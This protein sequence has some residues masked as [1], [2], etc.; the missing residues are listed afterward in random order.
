MNSARENILRVLRDR[1]D[2]VDPSQPAASPATDV[3]RD[4]LIQMFRSRAADE[5]ATSAVVERQADVAAEIGRY[6]AEQGLASAVHVLGEARE[7]AL[8]WAS[9]PA[10]ECID[11]PP[12]KDGSSVVTGCLAG[13]AEAGVIVTASAAGYPVEYQFLAQTHI[14]VLPSQYLL[15]D[16]ESLWTLARKKFAN[17]WPRMLNW[18]VGPSRTADLGVPSKLGAHGPAR[19]HVVIVKE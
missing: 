19:L 10:L 4:A 13:I 3:T 18:I 7:Q 6:L 8:G 16:F 11:A 14:V 12:A 9:E 17:G 2:P 5:A 1:A 15:V